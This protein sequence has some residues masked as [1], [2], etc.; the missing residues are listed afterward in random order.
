MVPLSCRRL[1]CPTSGDCRL[2][3]DLAALPMG[4]QGCR[5]VLFTCMGVM[6]CS[7]KG[8]CYM[9]A[10]RRLLRA[11]SLLGCRHCAARRKGLPVR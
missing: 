7:L 11:L 4:S 8:R 6:P 10:R 9:L 2:A 3:A 5:Q 1:S